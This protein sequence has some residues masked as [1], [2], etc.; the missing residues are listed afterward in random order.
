MMLTVMWIGLTAAAGYDVADPIALADRDTGSAEFVNN[1]DADAA[2]FPIPAGHNV[3]P[4]SVTN[5]WT[6]D[7]L[8]DSWHDGVNWS[9]GVPVAGQDVRIETAPDPRLTNATAA[10][11]S[12]YLAAGRTLTVEGWNSVLEAAEMT[13]AGTLTHPAQTATAVDPLT[14]EWVPDHRIWLKGSNITVAAGGALNADYVGYAPEAGPGSST[15]SRSGASHAGAGRRGFGGG[16]I[17]PPYGDPAAPWQPGSG[18]SSH[19]NSRPGGGTIR[20]EASGQLHV[21]GE[22][23]ARG[24][25]AAGTHGLGGSGGSIWLTCH[26]FS[27]AAT[28]WIAVTG[29][30]G[31]NYG[32][33]ASAGRIALHYDTQAQKVLEESV[34]PVRFSGRGGPQ[35]SNTEELPTAMSS[36][37]LPDALF[38]ESAIDGQRFFYNRLVIAGFTDW[39]VPDLTIENCVLGLP[40]GLQLTVANDLVLTNNAGLHLFAAPVGDPLTEAGASVEVGGDLKIFAGSWLHPYADNTNGATVQV[41]VDGNLHIAEEGGIDADYLG[42][43]V[44]DGPGEPPNNRGGGG[45]G[46][47]G[48]QGYDGNRGGFPY[49]DSAGPIQAGSGG[50]NLSLGGQGGGAIRLYVAG[51]AEIHGLVTARGAPGIRNHGPGGSGG[52][53][54]LVCQTL[55]GSDS[56]LL[57]VDGGRGSFYGGSGGGGRIALHYDVA[58]QAALP[59]QPQVRFHAFTQPDTTHYSLNFKAEMGT[60]AL[61]DTRLLAPLASNPALLDNG[62]F[63][64]VRLLLPDLTWAPAGL[65]IE[66]GVIGFEE[67]FHLDVQGDLTLGT[68][69]GLHLHAAPTNALYGA[70]LDVAG[71]LTVAEGG[72]L[73]PHAH[74]VE[75]SIVGLFADGNVIVH[76]GGGIDADGKGWFPVSGNSQGDGA[77][78][79]SDSG[80]GYGGHG[81]GTSG[82]ETY[83]LAAL[84]LEPG[85][86]GG[87]RS[88]GGFTP[89]GKGGGAIHLIAGGNA[90]IDGLLS[91]DGYNGEYYQG[92]GGSGGSIFLAANRVRGGGTLRARGRT[93]AANRASGGGGRIAVWM[94]VPRTA[95]MQRIANREPGQLVEAYPYAYFQGDLDVS[96]LGAST[97][98]PAE[99]GT[100]SFYTVHGTTVLVR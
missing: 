24:Q 52:G 58:A 34:P 72:W 12:F 29:G 88:R 14:G 39:S 70:R 9:A 44:N 76:D 77:G 82:G 64:H 30:S 65:S 36:L 86:P 19:D 97:E 8:T 63:W 98:G 49:G 16:N 5:F 59:Q 61:P 25:N 56:G 48:G 47:A 42:Y 28:G 62:R 55:T 43:T 84:P 3:V 46:G 85:S 26:T 69:S 87:W 50:G 15:V 90:E 20:V 67:G 35:G 33:G 13:I 91:A 23:R 40:D 17:N 89:T 27:G 45:Y 4:Y 37:Y 74:G 57:R 53:I 11:G 75:G 10:L 18:G 99:A 41:T 1:N 95:I 66:E 60:L 94:Y 51:K 54:K 31:N 22:L 2:E 93:G 78:N 80:G 83:G 68:D 92:P 100:K 32:A 7:G 71:N 38:I 81:G 96:T 6:G 21:E 79:N 73:Y